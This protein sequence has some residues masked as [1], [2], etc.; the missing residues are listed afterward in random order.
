MIVA[1]SLWKPYIQNLR[2]LEYDVKPVKKKGFK[3]TNAGPLKTMDFFMA[4]SWSG[5]A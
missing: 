5:T 3:Y 2:K 4:W 1:Y